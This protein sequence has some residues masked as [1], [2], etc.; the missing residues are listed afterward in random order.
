MKYVTIHI[1][2]IIIYICFYDLL[3]K[4]II[5]KIKVFEVP[6]NNSFNMVSKDL[7]LITGYRNL[8]LININQ[9]NSLRIIN[10]PN[11]SQIGDSCLLNRKYYSYW[12]R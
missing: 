12:S 4:K 10:V 6:S 3:K 1:K 8:Y 5:N 11:S 2:K 9:R 7:L